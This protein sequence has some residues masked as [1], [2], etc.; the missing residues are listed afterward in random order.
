M[1]RI[2]SQ[3]DSASTDLP[4]DSSQWRHEPEMRKHIEAEVTHLLYTQA[5]VGFL[6]TLLNASILVA[7]LH[8]EVPQPT[9]LYAWLGIL[10]ALVVARLVLVRAYHHASPT[11][12]QAPRWRR[13]FLLGIV[14][15][16]VA[17][18]S[19]SLLVFP[20]DLHDQVFLA[21]VLGGMSAGAIT[22]MASAQYVPLGFLI[23]VLGPLAVR[24]FSQGGNLGLPMGVMVILFFCGLMLAARQTR[25]TTI[26]TLGLR[27]A[28]L[29]LIRQVTQQAA[30]LTETNVSL[31]KESARHQ[32]TLQALQESLIRFDLAVQGTG[33]GIWSADFILDANISTP[34]NIYFSPRFSELLGYQ[35]HEFPQTFQS[36]VTHLHP[37][38][39]S[40]IRNALVSHLEQRTPY[41]EEFRMV[42]KNGDLRWF[43]ARGQAFWDQEGHP[44]RMAGSMRD[45][46]EQKAT[47]AALHA[48]ETRYQQLFENTNDGIATFAIDGVVTEVNG[49]AEFI[50]GWSREEMVGH[51]QEEFI[52][53][54]TAAHAREYIRR[55]LA[56]EALPSLL[57][58][59][60]LH[61]DGRVVPIEAQAQVMRN[62]AGVPFGVQAIFRD[63]TE[64]KR[65]EE[66]LERRVQQRTETLRTVNLQ[67]EFEIAE[68]RQVEESLRHSE[69]LFRSLI[70]DAS[71]LISIVDNEGKILYI[72]PS[73]QRVLGYTPEDLVGKNAFLL[74]HPDDLPKV[75]EAFA[76]T[77]AGRLKE[78]SH[79]T[80]RFRHH[81]GAWRVL[82]S[83]G[84]SLPKSSTIRGMIINSRDVTDRKRA[85][86]ALQESEVRYRSLVESTHDLIQSVGSDGRFMFVNNAWLTTLGYT[87]KEVPHLT[88]FDIIHPD[89]QSH[90]LTLLSKVL[91]GQAFPSIR[92]AFVTK[93]GRT[94]PVE[95]S[96]GVRRL[97]DGRVA[98]HGFFRDITERVRLEEEKQR[99]HLQ[100][101]QMQ[102]LQAVGVLAG[103]VAHD[104][105]NLLTPILG[106]SELLKKAVPVGTV[107]R[108][109]LEEVLKAGQRAKELVQQLLTFSRSGVH[110]RQPLDLAHEVEESLRMLTA[111][112]PKTVTISTTLPT[113]Y[114]VVLADPAQIHRVI[115]NLGVNALHAM[116]DRGGELEISLDN[117]DIEEQFAR[118]HP[119][120]TPGTY[121][122]LRVR[123]S[124]CGMTAEV[125]E[126]IF[127]P[128]FTTK[129]IGEGT[130]LGLSVVHGV[131]TS[132]GGAIT[133]ESA[134][135]NGTTFDVYLPCGP[136]TVTISEPS[137]SA[138]PQGGGC[139]LCV[140]DE[141]TVTLVMRQML[142]DL[143]Y[144]VVT[145]TSGRE[146][147][148]V[149]RQAP[150]RFAVVVLSQTMPG[151]TGEQLAREFRT[152]HPSLPVVLCVGL[153]SEL[154]EEQL[155]A[156]GAHGGILKKPFSK[157][158]LSNALQ[159]ALGAEEETQLL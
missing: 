43:H 71:D 116:K 83:A 115:M 109:N 18:G 111:M 124:G 90:C 35:E 42:S 29:D 143:G 9:R 113:S 1:N 94:I 80:Y 37:E 75:L 103:G 148:V 6:A 95:G 22:I 150:G 41:E 63:I 47:Q 138:M 17:W 12:E 135:G 21:F 15:I 132:Y 146:A 121:N 16:G 53:E 50:L 99:L 30:A 10:I 59:E 7:V 136:G 106:F 31:Q 107:A 39:R 8:A 48:S 60:L 86:E 133:V 20:P 139:I 89:F 73:H 105:N 24:F 101:A 27:F 13:L 126:R 65:I 88:L 69:E 44:I 112:S 77:R 45:I 46:T 144:E 19:A 87:V 129:P 58:L 128:F 51:H 76:L 157:E 155:Q 153:S 142:E 54:K 40:R 14:S 108:D 92:A 97:E 61:K 118:L 36:W 81:D 104:F 159:R 134:P 33:E 100:I 4:G 2:P 68:R 127:D 85:E 3:W 122:K 91:A 28:N 26:E 114:S 67:L 119:P 149:F 152:V 125:M 93:D 66:D 64:R 110:V 25:A 154:T 82:E 141:E 98:T 96:V 55:L 151:L 56:G 78:L 32:M 79:P 74:I 34:R 72:S 156:A 62:R 147:I 137:L 57:E 70:E 131:V 52:A 130:G 123:D 23:P 120:L 102:K 11:V 158:E 117:V 84:K 38:D 140:D 145:A 49:G 5:P